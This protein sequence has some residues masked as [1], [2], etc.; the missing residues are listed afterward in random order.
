MFQA[1]FSGS[2]QAALSLWCCGHHVVGPRSASGSCSPAGVVG[3]R[4]LPFDS[5]VLGPGCS[6]EARVADVGVNGPR[7]NVFRGCKELDGKDCQVRRPAQVPTSS[8][9]WP[10]RR[11]LKD[12][13]MARKLHCDR[14]DTST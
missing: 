1:V 9:V 6:P 5:P 10:G 8:G 11:Q 12:W 14:H 2:A 4:S 3:R 13:E 7:R